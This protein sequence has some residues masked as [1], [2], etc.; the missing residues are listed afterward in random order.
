M[1]ESAEEV[2][3]RVVAAVGEGGRLPVPDITTWD[4]F[5]WEAVGDTLVTRPLNPPA[6]EPA[7]WG[8]SADKPCS[9]CAGFPAERIV[10]EDEHWVL[11]HEGKP[12][13]LPIVLQLHPREHLDLPDLGDDLAS[14]LGRISVRL[15]RIIENLDHIGRVHVDRWGD[16]AAHLHLWFFARTA[17]LGQAIGSYAVE[18]D[19]I[20]PPGSE[21]VWRADLRT[22]GTKLAN[23]GGHARA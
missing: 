2:H 23:W 11:T 21:D 19:E 4:V 8:E 22:I 12:S 13:G 9:S 16:G 6:D 14:E 15:T 7:R 10:W 1:A 5:P 17:R 3:A 20:I 18:W